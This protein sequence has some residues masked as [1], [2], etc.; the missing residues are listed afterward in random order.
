VLLLHKSKYLGIGLGLRVPNFE[1]FTSMINL[2][3]IFQV[4]WFGPSQALSDHN[5]YGNVSL[6]IS[7]KDLLSKYNFQAYYIDTIETNKHISSRILLSNFDNAADLE[8]IDW[9]E[10]DSFSPI[11]R[12]PFNHAVE[13][14]DSNGDF[15]EHEL[16][17]AIEV[18]DEMCEW[19][20]FNCDIE[21]NNHQ[22]ANDR[23]TKRRYYD[24]VC[25]R[26]NSSGEYC[27]FK[28]NLKQARRVLNRTF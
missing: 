3:V 17:V 15:K 7:M 28:Y 27:P 5:Y 20:Y 22:C 10:K 26:F 12:N 23:D 13:C 1:F 16:E 2:V 14:Y 9:F 11:L 21:A 4:L 24:D 19:L 8:E 18:D 25:H 6:T